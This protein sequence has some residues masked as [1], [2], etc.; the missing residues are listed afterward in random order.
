LY[1][2]FLDFYPKMRTMSYRW[3]RWQTQSRS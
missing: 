2:F 3:S 1:F